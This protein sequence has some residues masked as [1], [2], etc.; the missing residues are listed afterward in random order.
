MLKVA[1]IQI[2]IWIISIILFKVNII[3]ITFIE[4]LK[5]STIP[6]GTNLESS[7]T[8]NQ[9]LILSSFLGENFPKK[10]N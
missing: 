4:L 9:F 8:L 6:N 10:L 5:K 7:S 1:Q 2:K 3:I